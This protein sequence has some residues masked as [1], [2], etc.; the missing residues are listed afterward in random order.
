MGFGPC[1]NGGNG[2]NSMK[3]TNYSIFAK[4]VCEHGLAY[5]AEHTARLGFDAVEFLATYKHAPIFESVDAAREGKRLL[6]SYGLSVSCYSM[7]ADLT[8]AD[9]AQCLDRVLYHV[10]CAAVLG[11]PYFHHTLIPAYKYPTPAFSYAEALETVSE[12]AERIVAHCAKHGIVCLYEPQGLYMNGVKGLSDLLSEMRKRHENVGICGDTGNSLFVD[13]PA[14]EIFSAFA[15]D[16]RHIHVK[17][18]TVTEPDGNECRERS[19]SGKY[20]RAASLGKGVND[21][22]KL[23][24]YVKGYDGDV[25]MEFV[26]DDDEMRASIEYVKELLH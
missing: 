1:C 22:E 18:Y 14:E 19:L 16:I 7:L 11:A 26:C 12:K 4:D 10:E 3:I 6:D 9:P 8:V 17:D 21:F 23:F 25:S 20:I 5:A 2:E 15:R 13:V 24:S